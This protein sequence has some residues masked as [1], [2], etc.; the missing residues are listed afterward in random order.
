MQL[1]E[2]WLNNFKSKKYLKILIGHFWVILWIKVLEILV[3]LW[4]STPEFEALLQSSSFNKC[5]PF[6]LIDFLNQVP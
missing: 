6:Q 3:I 5:M 2:T 1:D 4:I